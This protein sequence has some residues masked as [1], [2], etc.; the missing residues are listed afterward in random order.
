[1][2]VKHSDLESIGDV[3]TQASPTK[4]KSQG[5]F[6]Q[7]L[8]QSHTDLS[9]STMLFRSFVRIDASVSD[10]DQEPGTLR[11]GAPPEPHRCIRVYNA[12]SIVCE[13]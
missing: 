1:M 4:T 11:A 7:V 2:Q 12:F 13:D 6:E 3:S 8:R 5:H 9:G 10:Q